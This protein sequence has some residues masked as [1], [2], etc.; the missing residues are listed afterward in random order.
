[1]TT[2]TIPQVVQSCHELLL[3]LIPQLDKFPRSRRFTLG[4]QL[5]MRPGESVHAETCMM[6]VWCQYKS[7]FVS[8]MVHG[9][10]IVRRRT[11]DEAPTLCAA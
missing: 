8:M 11:S 10:A 7:S 6:D 1:M 9:I 2:P 3:W 5:K 4:E